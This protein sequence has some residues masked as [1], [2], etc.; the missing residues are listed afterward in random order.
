M[1]QRA[2]GSRILTYLPVRATAQQAEYIL[3]LPR[4]NVELRIQDERG[5]PLPNADYGIFDLNPNSPLHNSGVSA[6]TDAK[7]WAQLYLPPAEY[8]VQVDTKEYV[9]PEPPRFVARENGMQEVTVTLLF[10][11]VQ[12]AVTVGGQPTRWP[13]LKLIGPDGQVHQIQASYD[14]R[15]I[16]RLAPGRYSLVEVDT[17]FREYGIPHYFGEGYPVTVAGVDAPVVINVALPE[18]NVQGDAVIDGQPVAEGLLLA[19]PVGADWTLRSPIENGRWQMYLSAGQY[20]VTGI[21]VGNRTYDRSELLTVSAEKAPAPVVTTST[22]LF[23]DVPLDHWARA[24]LEALAAQNVVRGDQWGRFNPERAV[25]RAEFATLLVR[26]L[27]FERATPAQPTFPDVAPTDWFYADAEAVA[28]AGLIQG[29]AGQFRPLDT[30][31]RQ[32]MAAILARTLRQ[33]GE[34]AGLPAAT[35]EALRSAASPEAVEAI[36]SG[37][38]DGAEVAPWAKADVA[39]THQL[40]LLKG[41]SGSR[42]EPQASATRLEAVVALKRLLDALG[43]P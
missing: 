40:G 37:V 5:M 18:V 39:L 20:R 6:R 10:L 27:G 22:L 34:S 3:Q 30:I 24:D 13:L 14:G 1:I 15:F 28:R 16:S 17:F 8:Y 25:T 33:R 2:D 38:A 4:P 35:A 9:Q 23:P 7:G 11:N 12:G 26:T 29:A 43:E 31:A 42:Y 19:E 36:L 21:Q 32:E 41:R